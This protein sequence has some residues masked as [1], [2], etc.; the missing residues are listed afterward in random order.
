MYIFCHGDKGGVGKSF[1][2]TTLAN[3]ALD[4]KKE[5][6]LID[7]DA[8]NADV[9]RLFKEHVKLFRI[10]L[11]LKEGW[12]ELFNTLEENENT[13][14]I[15]NFP[16][17]LGSYLKKDDQGK[18]LGKVCEQLKHDTHMFFLLNRQKDSVIL[19]RE[20]LQDMAYLSKVYAVKNI[21]FGDSA[22]FR[23][24][25]KSNTAKEFLENGGAVIDFPDLYDDTADMLNEKNTLF[26]NGA[27]VL[28]LG[29]RIDLENWV[30]STFSIFDGLN[31]LD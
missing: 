31:L 14:A 27:D 6:I 9:Q 25:D 18:L 28:K 8:R 7:A 2:A 30:T 15:F 22:K 24:F 1:F 20:A 21:Y 4:R 12:I 5:F 19:F 10:N 17:G 11:S 29:E 13:H 23:I 3:W 26:T 16:A